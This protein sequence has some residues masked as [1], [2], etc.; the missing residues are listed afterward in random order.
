MR[1]DVYKIQRRRPMSSVSGASRAV[2]HVEH[3]P[4]AT[5]P[6]DRLIAVAL[7]SRS[8]RTAENRGKFLPPRPTKSVLVGLGGKVQMLGFYLLVKWY[9]L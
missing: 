9:V 3:P 5:P 4:S 6:N 2:A 1:L 8:P 7:I